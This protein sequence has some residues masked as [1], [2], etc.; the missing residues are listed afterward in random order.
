MIMMLSCASMCT[1]EAS[2]WTSPG[3]S[4][5]YTL[6]WLAENTNAVTEGQEQGNFFLVG[7]VTISRTDTLTFSAGEYLYI[8]PSTKIDIHGDWY[9]N[10]Q[11]NDKVYV[12]MSNGQESTSVNIEWTYHSPDDNTYDINYLDLTLCYYKETL[13][14]GDINAYQSNFY[15]NDVPEPV[16]RT[17]GMRIWYLDEPATDPWSVSL[18]S[19]FDNR[20]PSTSCREVD[21]DFDNVP[22]QWEVDNGLDPNDASDAQDDEDGDFLTN[23]LEWFLHTNPRLWDTDGDTLDDGEEYMGW[24]GTNLYDSDPLK[25]DSDDDGLRD[26]YEVTVNA[27][28]GNEYETD[29]WEADTD[30]DLFD[31][32]YEIDNGYDP[33]D[34]DT[35]DDTLLDGRDPDP[36]KVNRKFAFVFEVTD[37]RVDSRDNEWD[38]DVVANSL[39]DHDWTV[40]LS[41]DIDYDDDL[42]Q[43]VDDEVTVYDP[44][45]EGC[46]VDNFE[47]S[48][49]AFWDRDGDEDYNAGDIGKEPVGNG[50]DLVFIYI[51]AWGGL[52]G[53][54]YRMWFRGE[55]GATDDDQSEDELEAVL[56]TYNTLSDRIE[57]IW[58]LSQYSYRWEGDLGNNDVLGA[59]D[60][61]I[62]TCQ[63]VAFSKDSS[64]YE[65]F[66]SD[67]NDYP[68]KGFEDTFD[69]LSDHDYHYLYDKYTESDDTVQFY[70]E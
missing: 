60:R 23:Y 25:Q 11:V 37:Y 3:A 2:G 14:C 33:T 4:Q 44:Q 54:N 20:G 51:A 36:D 10:G 12:T 15:T 24:L 8:Y 9:V 19:P 52:D 43:D 18:T 27:P 5:S 70:L 16:K 61:I 13:S 67:Y 47:K 17:D 26:D 62:V 50:H 59:N 21:G 31:D 48:W 39:D 46:T 64:L 22:D 63:G 35:D 28:Q 6:T 34:P 66:D 49:E 68:D 58:I 45:T 41:T 55:G 30:E 7:D 65:S 56:D 32:K 42:N 69:D 40:F 38:C 57:V 53:T 1:F 29:P